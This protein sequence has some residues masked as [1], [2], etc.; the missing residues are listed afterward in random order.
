VILDPGN[1]ALTLAVMATSHGDPRPDDRYVVTGVQSNN[2]DIFP[3]SST[4]E[5]AQDAQHVSGG[6]G[7]D[8]EV[9]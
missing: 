8:N 5:T 3:A 1:V 6:V 9:M 2:T 4:A 7:S